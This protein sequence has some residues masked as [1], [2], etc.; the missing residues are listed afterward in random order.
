MPTAKQENF[1]SGDRGP[2]SWEDPSAAPVG[3]PGLNRTYQSMLPTAPSSA[4]SSVPSSASLGSYSYLLPPS[5]HHP[6]GWQQSVPVSS[7]YNSSLPA[8]KQEHSQ[9]VLSRP[10]N[11]VADI[12]QSY[13][14]ISPTGDASALLYAAHH[15]P[16]AYPIHHPPLSPTE[17]DFR[18][19]FADSPEMASAYHVQQH[20]SEGIVGQKPMDTG[21]SPI[22]IDVAAANDMA[23]NVPVVEVTHE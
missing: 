13:G 22:A 4:A 21:A 20:H 15:H 16:P 2:G 9:F 23:R 3:W 7:T 18:S 12:A 17:H 1:A 19:W 5:T 8:V 10:T 14:Y 6:G 11:S